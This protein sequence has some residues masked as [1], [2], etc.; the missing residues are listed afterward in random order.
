MAEGCGGA[1]EEPFYFAERLLSLDSTQLHKISKLHAESDSSDEEYAGANDD[2]E[3]ASDH[4]DD[5][6][7]SKMAR[8][9]PTASSVHTAPKE[10][11]AG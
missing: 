6:H 3:E 8:K 1:P 4:D 11:P 9:D 7:A 10:L 2:A 5:A